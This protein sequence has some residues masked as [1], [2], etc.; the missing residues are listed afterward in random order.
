[1]ALVAHV[2]T[3]MPMA[4]AGGV[5]LVGMGAGVGEMR[6]SAESPNLA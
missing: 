5:G 4:I 3:L 1:M 2:M 6:R